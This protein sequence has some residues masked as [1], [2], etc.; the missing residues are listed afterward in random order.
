MPA[1]DTRWTIE[2]SGFDPGLEPTIEAVMA[3][4]N[5]Y[6]GTRAALEEGSAASRPSTFIA[7]VF[8]TPDRPQA[9]E[10]E[11]P[12]PELVVAP[13]WSRLRIVVDGQELRVDQCDL[14]GQRRVLDMRQGVLLREWRVRDAGGRVTSLR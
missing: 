13:D 1:A 5:G 2:V 6:S 10:L 4:V 8:N 14:V 11:A 9:P 7:G 3:L 12:I